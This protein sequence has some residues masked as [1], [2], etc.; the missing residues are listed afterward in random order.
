[1]RIHLSRAITLAA[2][3]AALLAAPP[4]SA[5]YSCFERNHQGIGNAVNAGPFPQAPRVFDYLARCLWLM[6]SLG[7]AGLNR[8]WQPSQAALGPSPGSP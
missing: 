2:T 1:M 5:Q 6:P 8:L 4:T 3:L 7:R